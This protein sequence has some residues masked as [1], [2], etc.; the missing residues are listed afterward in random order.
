MMRLPEI[1]EKAKKVPGAISVTEMVVIHNLVLHELRAVGRLWAIDLGAHAGKSSMMASSAMSRMGRADL[2]CMVDLIYDLENPAWWDTY[3][4]NAAKRDGNDVKHHIPW[5]IAKDPLQF[6]K[7]ID[8]HNSVSNLDVTLFGNSSMQFLEKFNGPFS[9]AFV[10]TDDHQAE[11]VMD[12][13]RALENEM[14]IGALIIFHDYGNYRGPVL[15]GDYLLS[16]GKYEAIMI[17][18]TVANRLVEKHN[19][20]GGNDSWAPPHHKYLGCFRR[21]R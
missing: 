7:I 15:A 3:Q 1:V 16:T 9:Y 6:P 21:V 2:F 12:E 11:L 17:D 10:D 14:A 8:W 5:P 20:E 19:L 13:A 18:W 4:G